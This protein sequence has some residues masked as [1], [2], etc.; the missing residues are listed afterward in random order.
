MLLLPYMGAAA[1]IRAL[2]MNGS[3]TVVLWCVI[4][5]NIET[6]FIDFWTVTLGI[7]TVANAK[8]NSAGDLTLTH[9]TIHQK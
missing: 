3:R 9:R 4:S 5:M 6:K 1:M 8:A 7:H 2:C